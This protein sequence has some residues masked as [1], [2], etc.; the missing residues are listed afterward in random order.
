MRRPRSQK[1][2]TRFGSVW[3]TVFFGGLRRLVSL[4]VGGLYWL[5]EAA[6]SYFS[7]PSVL[8]VIRF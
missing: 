1:K 4:I 2:E 6:S 7:P 8:A 5:Y 3:V